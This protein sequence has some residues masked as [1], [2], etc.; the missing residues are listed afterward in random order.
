MI[1]RARKAVVAV[2][3][4]AAIVAAEL[5]PGSPEGLKRWAPVVIGVATAVGVYGVRNAPIPTPDPPTI[6]PT[7]SPPSAVAEDLGPKP[8]R[9]DP[10]R[11]SSGP[12]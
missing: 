5:P 4:L 6:P 3:G 2:L 1:A 11:Y 10:S 9:P 12:Y 8:T 7:P